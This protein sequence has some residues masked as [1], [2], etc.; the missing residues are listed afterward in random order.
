VT[1]R[2]D[3]GYWSWSDYSTQRGLAFV[4][5]IKELTIHSYV[6]LARGERIRLRSSPWTVTDLRPGKMTDVLSSYTGLIVSDTIKAIVEAEDS[7]SLQFIPIAVPGH[8][9][10]RY[11]MLHVLGHV[12][13][14]DR[15]RSDI[16]EEDGL[17]VVR[18]I[19]L[20]SL[21]NDTP[22]IFRFEGLAPFVLV[23]DDLRRRLE[24]ASTTPGVF[25]PIQ[26]L[27]LN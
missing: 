21:P 2:Q 8:R 18:K 23:R 27:R 20:K 22:A 1:R 16:R 9:N 13:A 24:A 10:R 19:V 17:T 12:D 25:I 5:K 15:G 11:W 4:L 14:I 6:K 26:E 7:G 3:S